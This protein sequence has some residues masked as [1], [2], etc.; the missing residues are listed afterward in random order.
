MRAWWRSRRVP[1]ASVSRS[2][3]R[4]P[5]GVGL[6]A[7]AVGAA[8]AGI[9]DYI[10]PTPVAVA[11]ASL[12]IA[13]PEVT[14]GAGTT[15]TV[16]FLARDAAGRP[17]TNREVRWSS[18][19]TL[20][21]RINENGLLTAIDAGRAQVVVSMGG[22]S[23]TAQVTVRPKP[24]AT[25][26]V[27]P[28]APAL[29]VGE[30]VQLTA[31]PQDDAGA[32]LAGRV[33]AW[34]SDD[35]TI[36]TVDATGFV[37][38][39]T[40]GVATITAS[41]E[42]RTAAVGVQVSPMP[43][44][45]V[46]V[47]P[48][49]SQL[50]VGET[51]QLTGVARDAIGVPLAARVLTWST[52]DPAVASVSAAGLVVAI[53]PGS[54]T[55]TAAHDGVS[56]TALVEVTLRPIG[57]VLVSPSQATLTVGDQLALGVQVTDAFGTVLTGRPVSF[58]SSAPSVAA[59]DG[60]GTVRALSAGTS[61]ITVRSEGRAGT[62]QLTVRPTPVASLRIDPAEATLLEGDSLVLRALALDASGVALQGRT[63]S[64]VSGA[65]T[66]ASV[67]AS[68]VVRALLPGSAVVFAVVDGRLA[69]ARV[70]VVALQVASVTL[71]PSISTLQV[72]ATRDLVA[73]VRAAD[74]TLISG[75]PVAFRSSDPAVAVVSSAGRVRALSS[76]VTRLDATVDGVTGSLTI[77]VPPAVGASVHVARP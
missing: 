69:T 62:M 33:V 3:S 5:L 2:T 61:T 26:L 28:T 27:T 15:A 6:I 46:E 38:A 51:T 34:Q 18:S 58:E 40:P 44:A 23:A 59:V 70:E 22:R 17:V 39:L 53:A 66:V 43:V 64:W 11:V 4:L 47:S 54:A 16:P 74:G 49:R 19:D 45:R 76:G 7:A 1:E 20:V 50:V 10:G 67:S 77:S 36:A 32:P 21:V 29:Q 75:R 48:A 60:Q 68:G 55:I 73:T 9:T 35:A 37:R 41:S 52:S 72:G 30:V 24:V 42:G 65:P 57:A 8:C 63:I 25:L 13:T 12:E 31:L 14:L 56:G 71:S